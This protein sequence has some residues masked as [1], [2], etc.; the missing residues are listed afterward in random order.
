[1]NGKVGVAVVVFLDLHKRFRFVSN[2]FIISTLSG[3]SQK[4]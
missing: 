4:T 1:M 3:H 2:S